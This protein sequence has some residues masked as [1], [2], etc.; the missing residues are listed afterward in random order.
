MGACGRC[1]PL[2]PSRRPGCPGGGSVSAGARSRCIGFPRN[3]SQCIVARRAR[4]AGVATQR[5][6]SDS[7][8]ADYIAGVTV[9]R[10]SEPDW[11]EPKV[12]PRYTNGACPD[13]P[14]ESDRHQKQCRASGHI[15][16]KRL[17]RVHASFVRVRNRTVSF[18]R[19]SNPVRCPGRD[20][21]FAFWPATKV[22]EHADRSWKPGSRKGT[23]GCAGR[24]QSRAAAP[25]R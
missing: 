16:A 6:S 18:R 12:P 9:R 3:R 22:E 15:A 11:L 5:S 23:A 13:F 8:R 14:L 2:H 17:F 24:Q 10:A 7:P 25:P 1:L 20:A 19:G 4:P 21:P